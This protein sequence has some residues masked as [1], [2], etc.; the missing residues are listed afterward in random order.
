MLKLEQRSKFNLV[1]HELTWGALGIVLHG[2][3]ECVVIRKLYTQMNFE[4]YEEVWG[5][6]GSGMVSKSIKYLVHFRVVTRHRTPQQYKSE[7]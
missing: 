2:L 6:I 3:W 1:Q 4:I 5:M 7:L